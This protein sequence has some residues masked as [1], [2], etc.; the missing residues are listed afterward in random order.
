MIVRRNHCFYGI[1]SLPIMKPKIF[2]R[3]VLPATIFMAL[4]SV[5]AAKPKKHHAVRRA[6]PTTDGGGTSARW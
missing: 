2:S 3:S 5:A 4:L 6:T 1:V